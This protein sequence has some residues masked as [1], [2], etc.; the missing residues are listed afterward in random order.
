MTRPRADDQMGGFDGNQ[1]FESDL[2]IP[3]D[4]DSGTLQD[5]VLIHIPGKAVIIVNHDDLRGG[6]QRRTRH[7]LVG[8]VV[9]E[10]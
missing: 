3:E 1:L 9:N 5:Q 7:R 6:G 8:R 4:G 2:V 10:V